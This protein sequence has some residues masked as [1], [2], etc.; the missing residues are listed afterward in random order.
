[1]ESNSN[2][3]KS[4]DQ[5][6]F[7][8]FIT[9]QK[10]YIVAEIRKKIYPDIHGKEKSQEIMSGKKKKIFD[11]AIKN[12]IKTIF[13]DMKV[14]GMSLYDEQ[15]RIDLYREIYKDKGFPDFIYRDDTQRLRLE[16]KDKKCYYYPDSDFKTS[17]GIG[18]LRDTDFDNNI[19]HIEIKGELEEFSM[20]EVSRIL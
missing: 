14:G 2:K 16:Y 9:L 19:C 8:F 3:R 5:K 12:S 13:P 18:I 1:M 17:K 11:M 10:E 4:R 20:D 6:F 15:L 7:E